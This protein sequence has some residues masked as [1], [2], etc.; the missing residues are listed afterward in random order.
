MH[1]LISKAVFAGALLSVVILSACMGGGQSAKITSKEYETPYLKVSV[2]DISFDGLQDDELASKLNEEYKNEQVEL[3]AEIDK[4]A[5]EH[6]G[7]S[8]VEQN[9]KI[10]YDSAKWCSIVTDTYINTGIETTRRQG[11]TVDLENNK[12]VILS[13]LYL[14]ED[15]EKFLNQKIA[16]EVSK[17]TEYRDLWEQPH[18]FQN[19]DFYFSKNALVLFYQPYELSYYAKGVIEVSIPYEKLTGY[20]VV[21]E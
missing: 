3:L 2:Q 19:Q 9:H 6:E 20:L 8:L 13:D 17:K 10:T 16:E 14:G 5:Q 4:K 12:T 7:Q 1:H 15:S 21:P 18:V 11:K